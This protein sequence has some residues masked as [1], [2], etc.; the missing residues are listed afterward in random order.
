MT[1]TPLVALAAVS[2]AAHLRGE[3]GGP[4]WQVYLFKP[5]TTVL[6]FLAA[7]VPPPLADGRYTAGIAG[8]LLA[9]IAGDIFLMLP[10]DQFLAGL[11]CFL[12]AHLA[13]LLA[14]TAGVPPGQSPW[15]LLPLGAAA[16]GLLVLL[17][18]GLGRM[19]GPVVVYSAVILVMVWQAGARALALLRG[20][21]YVLAADVA[22]LVPDVMRH[23]L[24]LSYEALSDGKTAD[25][26]IARIMQAVPQPEAPLEAHVQVAAKA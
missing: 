5:L 7:V 1:A 12:V 4:K 24:V 20:R 21:A 6:L 10:G 8:G 15:L 13:Y 2:L 17:W 25:A 18:P 23:R 26:L 19:K 22:D 11:L 9:S 14:F 16:V 3:Y